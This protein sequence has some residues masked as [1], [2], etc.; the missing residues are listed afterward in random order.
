M[1]AV[2]RLMVTDAERQFVDFLAKRKL[3]YTSQRRTILSEAFRAKAHFTADELL[4]LTKRRDRSIGKA[5]L[6]RTLSLL[7]ESRL[8]EE[9]DFGSG[10][11]SYEPLLGHP[12]HDHL[13]CIRCRKILEFEN[14]EIERIQE[15]EA[16]KLGFKTIFHSHKLFGFCRDCKGRA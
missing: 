12:H 6:Y 8:L 11:K 7:K 4:D 5:T 2:A 3:K 9:Q 13:V 16:R 15:E 10:R 1:T 14:D